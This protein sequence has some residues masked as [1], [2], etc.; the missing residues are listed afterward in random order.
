MSKYVCA[1]CG[2]PVEC[3]EM[4]NEK[5]ET[6]VYVRTCQHCGGKIYDGR[7]WWDKPARENE[8]AIVRHLVDAFAK[9]LVDELK[10]TPDETPAKNLVTIDID[11]IQFVCDWCENTDVDCD[12]HGEDGGVMVVHVGSCQNCRPK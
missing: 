8:V 9:Y 5:G 6:V 11:A 7:P 4:E 1:Y 10:V 3:N 2:E 12:I